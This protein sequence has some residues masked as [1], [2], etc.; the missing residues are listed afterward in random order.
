MVFKLFKRK[1]APEELPDLA[2]DTIEKRT[3]IE[4]DKE[5][6]NSYLKE[7]E[8]QEK[9][10][11]SKV[12]QESSQEG[13]FN[14][15]QEDISVEISNLNKLENW[16]NN[17]FLPQDVVTDM[18]NYWEKQKS[19]NPMSVIGRNFQEKIKE[20]TVKLQALE[21]EWQAV[22]FQLVEKEE[23]LRKEEHELKKVLAEFVDLCKARKKKK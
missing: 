4:K 14:K 16:Y 23:E 6:I 18:R 1:E 8:P 21:R 2:T 10:D 3:Q 12:I 15:L 7:Q 17:K 5:A 19:S 22:Y 13:F 20:K 11:T 9:A